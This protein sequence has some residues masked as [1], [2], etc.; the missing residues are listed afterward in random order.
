MPNTLWIWQINS[1]SLHSVIIQLKPIK[2]FSWSPTDHMLLICTE[3][4]KLYTFTLSN[5]YIVDL[6][7][8]TNFNLGINKIQWN[9]D[10]K[11]FVASDKVNFYKIRII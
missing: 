11:S 9:V 3:N 8:D 7:T 6:I 2:S 1:L 4:A 10:G 5:V